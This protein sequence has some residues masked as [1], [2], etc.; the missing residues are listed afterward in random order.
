SNFT[1]HILK[2]LWP[3]K[4]NVTK[5]YQSYCSNVMKKLGRGNHKIF[6]TDSN[7]GKFVSI[8]EG[9]ILEEDD[10]GIADILA[11][12]GIPVLRLDKVK[13]DQIRG[14]CITYPIS[15]KLV[16]QELQANRDSIP[17]DTIYHSN[18]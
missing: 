13:L 14:N 1:P 4:D 9:R 12:L 6:W 11:N 7:G 8:K 10:E 17:W 2:N 16:C 15:G 3:I 18:G 5:T